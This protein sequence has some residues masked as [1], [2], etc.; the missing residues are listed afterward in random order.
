MPE[1]DGYPLSSYVFVTTEA[2]RTRTVVRA[3]AELEF[4]GCRILTAEQVIGGYDIIARVETPDLDV[5]ARLI[6][7]GIREVP[8]VLDVVASWCCDGREVPQ[9]EP[10]ARLGALDVVSVTHN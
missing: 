4:A 10:S 2:G 5:L 9:P 1:T 6:T 8:G 7:D 3:I